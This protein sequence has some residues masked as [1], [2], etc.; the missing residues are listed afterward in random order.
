M[1]TQ[2]HLKIGLMAERLGKGLQNL[3]QR[4]DSASDL[5][6]GGKKKRK[7]SGAGS[8]PVQEAPPRAPRKAQEAS[9]SFSTVAFLLRLEIYCPLLTT[10]Y[11]SAQYKRKIATVWIAILLCPGRDSNSHGRNC[12][13][14]PQSGV[15]TNFTTWACGFSE[16]KY[17]AYFLFCKIFS[18][19]NQKNLRNSDLFRTGT[20][21]PPRQSAVE[22]VRT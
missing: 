8:Q 17:S 14:P 6:G 18:A 15:S 3:V 13:P 5:P 12:P 9:G 19:K 4:F 2:G 11:L 21:Q 7:V 16:C 1:N 10:R 22:A 20:K